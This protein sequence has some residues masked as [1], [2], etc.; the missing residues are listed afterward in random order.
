MKYH[1]CF[2]SKIG[3]DFQK[4]SSAAVVIGALRVKEFSL[5]NE[6]SH[7]LLRRNQNSIKID[8]YL[9]YNVQKQHE[10]TVKHKE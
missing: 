1:N 8:C 4:L 6:I 9:V 7:G 2:F 10:Y 3:K 5:Y